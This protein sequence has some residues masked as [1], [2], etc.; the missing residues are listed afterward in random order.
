MHSQCRVGN[1]SEPYADARSS[2]GRRGAASPDHRAVAS[3]AAA[4]HSRRAAAPALGPA[5]SSAAAP[6]TKQNKGQA[7]TKRGDATLLLCRRNPMYPGHKAK[8]GHASP[9]RS[10]PNSLLWP[11]AGTPANRGRRTVCS[12]LRALPSLA[13]HSCPRSKLR[14]VTRNAWAWRG[15]CAKR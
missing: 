7:T 11:P 3:A 2:T 15:N 5:R 9:T 1:V 12:V 8:L 6:T 14:A 10:P 13:K 4:A